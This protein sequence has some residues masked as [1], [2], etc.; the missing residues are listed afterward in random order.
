MLV[1]YIS[2]FPTVPSC[3]VNGLLMQDELRSL[4][5]A[6]DVYVDPIPNAG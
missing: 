1:V 6:P 2:S 3:F 5:Q 4:G